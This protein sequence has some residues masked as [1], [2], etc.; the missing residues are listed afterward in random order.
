LKRQQDGAAAEAEALYRQALEADPH[1]PD[2]LQLLGL[3]ASAR[4]QHEEAVA[5]LRRAVAAAPDRA[6][7]HGKLGLVCKE[8]GQLREAEACLRRALALDARDA[9]NQ[10]VLG[11]VLGEQGDLDGALA[12]FRA[13]VRLRPSL[14][15]AHV[16]LGRALIKKQDYAAAIAAFQEALRL[17]PEHGEAYQGLA[18]A[19]VRSGQPAEAVVNYEQA[20]RLR[21]HQADAFNERGVALLQLGRVAEAEADFRMAVRLRPEYVKA[22]SNRGAALQKLGQLAEAERQFQQAI[23]LRPSYAMAHNNLGSLCLAQGRLTEAETHF[24][25]ALRLDPTFADAHSNL[26]NALT[27][28]GRM[29]E[30]QASYAEA[31]RL[32][33]T[34]TEAHANRAIAWLRAG[35]YVRGWAEYEWRWRRPDAPTRSFPQPCWDGSALAGRTILLY[36]EQGMGDAL[37]MVR[38]AAAVKARGGTVLVQCQAALIPL[39]ATCPGIDR[40]LPRGGPLPPFDV[41][42]PLMSL[43]RILGTTVET[44]PAP[45]PYLSADPV[46]VDNW[47]RELAL[48]EGFRVGIA[49]QGNPRYPSDRQRSLPL[50]SFE[51]LARVPGVR[52]ISLQKGPGRE[53]RAAV[54]DRFLVTDLGERLDSNGGAF[55]DTAAVMKS[56]DL[57]ISCDTAI[58]HLAGALDVP[59]W[60]A[61]CTISDWR[62][63]LG[64]ADTPWYPSMRLFR[65]HQL[66]DWAPVFERMAGELHRLVVRAAAAAAPLLVEVSAGELL[67]KIT[68]LEIKSERIR[69]TAQLRNVC[70]ELGALERVRAERLPV[71]AAL[72]PL[73]A[74]LRAVN[75]ALWEIEDAVRVCERS[76]DFGPRFIELARSV[77]QHNDRRAAL[78]RQIN[79]L[80]RSRLVEE[81]SYRL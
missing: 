60:L 27:D 14:A 25:A 63:L 43:P 69:D 51:P 46:L 56:L 68:I 23:A 65:Q 36:D 24:R 77:Y 81:K 40:L 37:Q 33:P 39:L 10:H 31:V 3:L 13:A 58:A 76:G 54:A 71:S 70:T 47:R 80:L 61:L 6:D 18:G 19:L 52:L 62:W 2:A 75:R 17:Q 38:Y 1:H 30:A 73:V 26:G 45:I 12:C 49:W 35:D 59:V 21:P 28:Q 9:D 74:E 5:F 20:L 78:K 8:A 64:R 4:G 42:A 41:Q 44:I 22:V 53:Q 15:Q 50:R 16:N 67:D 7:L 72:A 57:V 66:D 55:R 11:A 29:G 79:A 48:E 32:Q 34:S